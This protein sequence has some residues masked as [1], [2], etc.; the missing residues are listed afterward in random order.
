MERLSFS[1]YHTFSCNISILSDAFVFSTVASIQVDLNEA[2]SKPLASAFPQSCEHSCEQSLT[3]LF[4]DG[5][6]EL[7]CFLITF[8]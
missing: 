4:H 5:G 7:L 6:T 8:T 1:Q 2:H 3:L